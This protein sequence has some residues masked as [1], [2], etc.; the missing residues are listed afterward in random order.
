MNY[1]R[2]SKG[3]WALVLTVWQDLGE[4]R[5]PFEARWKNLVSEDGLNGDEMKALIFKG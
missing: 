4:R 3:S 1:K 2:V 5:T